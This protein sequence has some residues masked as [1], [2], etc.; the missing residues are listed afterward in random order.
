MWVLEVFL[1]HSSHLSPALLSPFECSSPTPKCNS[2]VYHGNRPNRRNTQSLK[3]FTFSAKGWDKNKVRL[4]TA[5]HPELAATNSEA[6]TSLRI[7]NLWRK[8]SAASQGGKKKCKV[9]GAS[10]GTTWCSD[11]DCDYSAAWPSSARPLSCGWELGTEPQL[12][13]ELAPLIGVIMNQGTEEL[14]SLLWVLDVVWQCW[15]DAQQP[16]ILIWNNRTAIK[17]LVFLMQEFFLM[18]KH[19]LICDIALLERLKVKTKYKQV[20]SHA[21]F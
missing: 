19:L 17:R 14:T 13:H 11:Y 4:Q 7:P 3:E 15:R 21:L 16:S 8:Q 18:K 2:T 12:A 1:M 20:Q 5:K 6:R 10:P 9:T